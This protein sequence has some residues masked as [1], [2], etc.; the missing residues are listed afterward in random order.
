[1]TTRIHQYQSLELAAS[2]RNV[3]IPSQA[4]ARAWVPRA[5][6]AIKDNPLIVLVGVWDAIFYGGVIALLAYL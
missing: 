6:A 2:V 3:R 4:R 5:V 1:M